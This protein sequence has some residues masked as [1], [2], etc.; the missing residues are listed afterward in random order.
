MT[1]MIAQGF[2]GSCNPKPTGTQGI[3]PLSNN[4]ILPLSRQID[5]FFLKKTPSDIVENDKNKQSNI[6][7]DLH[8][9]LK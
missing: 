3:Q 1:K 4:Y 9:G 8:E 6:L 5:F 2:Y 7:I